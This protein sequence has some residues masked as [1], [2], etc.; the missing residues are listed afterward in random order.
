MKKTLTTIAAA[1]CLLAHG[2][3]TKE[4]LNIYATLY[5]VVSDRETGEPMSG[6]SVTLQPGGKT[7]TTDANGAYEFNDL[8]AKQYTI[9][10]QQPG[11][12]VEYEAVSAIS[13]KRTQ[14]NIFLTKNS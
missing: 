14:K 6:A 1:L 10:V 3:C 8:D 9:T 4:P 11:Y 2:G 7:Q 13:A 5:G 12:K